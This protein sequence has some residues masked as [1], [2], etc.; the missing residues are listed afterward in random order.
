M[1]RLFQ[2]FRKEP[3][4]VGHTVNT[5]EGPGVITFARAPRR[6]G[7]VGLVTVNVNGAI[8]TYNPEDIWCYWGDY[9]TKEV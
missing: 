4:G 8:Y 3:I 2:M 6:E 7:Q 5:L 9:E 1:K